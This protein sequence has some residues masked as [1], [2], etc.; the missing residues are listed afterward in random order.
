[1]KNDDYSIEREA[2]EIRNTIEKDIMLFNSQDF[3]REI[4]SD[5]VF[6]NRVVNKPG[7]I[8]C[9]NKNNKWYI[10]HV[11]D[12][13]NLLVNG[14]FSKEGIIQALAIHLHIPSSVADH[15]ISDEEFDIYLDGM[16]PIEKF[17]GFSK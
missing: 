7:A 13:F 5:D 1:M 2:N 9:Y 11:D 4:K 12:K 17:E 3:G 10:Y 16:K 15:Y 6:I 14:P 8:G